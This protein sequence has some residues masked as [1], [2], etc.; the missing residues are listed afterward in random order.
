[1]R[2]TL[3]CD[4]RQPVPP[5]TRTDKQKDSAKKRNNSE[6]VFISNRLT[7]RIVAATAGQC[8]CK[9]D[10]G[11]KGPA[12]VSR[13]FLQVLLDRYRCA[14]ALSTKEDVADVGLGSSLPQ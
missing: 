14:S 12:S 8:M 4:I 1:M 9:R 6:L 10:G 3:S 7:A 11:G 13:E 2:N 5:N